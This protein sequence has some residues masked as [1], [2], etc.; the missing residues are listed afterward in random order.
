MTMGKPVS[1]NGSW[2]VSQDTWRT[3]PD[4]PFLMG[5]GGPPFRIA[6]TLSSNKINRGAYLYSN[7]DKIAV[8]EGDWIVHISGWVYTNTLNC[9]NIPTIPSFL[10]SGILHI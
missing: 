2:K 4:L 7:P 9:K 3:I 1:K 5:V 6:F 8:G 10:M